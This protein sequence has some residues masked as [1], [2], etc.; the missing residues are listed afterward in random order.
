MINDEKIQEIRKQLM[1]GVPSGELREELIRQGYSAEDIEKAFAPKPYDMRTW[2][3]C[4]ALLLLLAGLCQVP[5]R[6]A[7][8]L[9]VLSAA[10][11]FQYYRET[12]RL[13]DRTAQ[14]HSSKSAEKD[15]TEPEQRTY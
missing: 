1:K 14:D 8:L 2:Y 5:N 10:I 11:I 4:A 3:L 12:E 6:N 13:K 15:N 7:Y 9:L